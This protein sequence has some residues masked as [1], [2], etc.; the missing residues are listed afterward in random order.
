MAAISFSSTRLPLS[1]YWDW[2][3]VSVLTGLPPMGAMQR[4]Q[5][6]R[7]ST[8]LRRHLAQNTCWQ[9]TTTSGLSGAIRQMAQSMKIQN[10]SI[11]IL[12]LTP[13]SHWDP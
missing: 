6:L 1:N 10:Y 2:D 4:G 5:Q 11:Q 12:L 13:S 7:T 3:A 9:Q 8:Q